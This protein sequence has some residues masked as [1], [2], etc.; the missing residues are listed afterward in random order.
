MAGLDEAAYRELRLDPVSDVDSVTKGRFDRLVGG[1]V[2]HT[3]AMVNILNL[4]DVEVA[5][6]R[7]TSFRYFW[8]KHVQ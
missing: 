4:Y 5:R 2:N 1:K 8:Q 3:N 6:R 7:S